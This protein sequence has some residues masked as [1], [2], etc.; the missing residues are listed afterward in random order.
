MRQRAFTI[1]E[2]LLVILLLG[3]IVAFTYPDLEALMHGRSLE[4]S[5]DR[6]RTL[7]VMAHARA[8]QDGLRYRIQ[9]PGTPDPLDPRADKEVDVPWETL[10]P[11]VLRQ[12]DALENPDFY[13]PFPG[14]WKDQPIMQP[15]TRCVGVFPGRPNFDV[16]ANNPIAGPP[17][18]E[19]FTTFVPLTFNIE[20]TCD[21]VTFVLTDLPFDVQIERH[22]AP[23]ILHVIVDGRTGQ[24]WIQR[25]L[26][27]E[28]VE[29]LQKFG[30][31]PVF[32]K[33]FTDPNEIT[34]ERIREDNGVIM[35]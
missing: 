24:T 3:L 31:T 27:V 14:E 25:A 17:I 1:I 22:H 2:V 5:A 9:F 20:G 4:E 23:R 10:Q 12:V 26:R 28:E 33:D 32:Y 13:G 35:F 18:T 34:E 30:A 6:L 8:M 15:G 16:S 29:A 7:I 11:E 21:W 19:E